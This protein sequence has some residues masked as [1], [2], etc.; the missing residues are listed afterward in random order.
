MIKN[1]IFD[2]GR[3]LVDF[4]PDEIMDQLGIDKD[5]HQLLNKIMFHNPLWNEFD[6][7]TL[8]ADEIEEKFFELAP[9]KKEII[10]KV[11]RKVGDMIETRSYTLPWLQD[12]KDRGY[13]LYILSNY[14]SYTYGLTKDKLTFLD[15]MDG[16]VFSYQCK[17]IKPERGIYDHLLQQ[18]HLDPVECVFLDD[19]ED[20][21]EAGRE[22]GMYG[23]VFDSFENGSALLENLL[24]TK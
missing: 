24:Q 18:Y 15:L 6:R 19:R 16:I 1:I 11:F 17:M 2:V 22:L 20:N 4:K 7:S 21:I 8:S 14:A 10:T 23:V 13:H 3:V 12:L 5:T 9:D